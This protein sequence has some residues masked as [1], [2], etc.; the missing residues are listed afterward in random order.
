MPKRTIVLSDL[1]GYSALLEN[2]LADAE[3]GPGDRLV[4]AG[5]LVDIGPDDCV[6][7]A[8]RHGATILAG[9]HEVSA[10][11]GVGISPQ[12]DDTPARGPEFARR[13]LT[14]EWPLAIAVEGW[15]VTHGGLSTAFHDAIER[16]GRDAEVL[17]AELNEGFRAEL[18]RFFR[19]DLTEWDAGRSAILGSEFGPLWFRAARPV[20]VPDGVRQVVGHTPCELF[21]PESLAALE[22]KSFLLVDPGAHMMDTPAGHFRYA[23]IADGEARV[24]NGCRP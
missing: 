4:V 14:G 22:R 6:A 1:H 19:R 17:A 23:V 12:N 2:A 24:V 7:A 16:A 10:A 18:Q 21:P 15:L 3:F 9:N 5:D 13:F 8:E 11:L 20:T